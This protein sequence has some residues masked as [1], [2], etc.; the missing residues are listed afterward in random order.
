MT[1]LSGGCRCGKIRYTCDTAPI[2]VSFCYCTD[3]QKAS[4]GPFCNYAVV[5]AEAVT[6]NQGATVHYTVEASTGNVVK[7]EFCAHCG[8][9]LFASTNNVF[10]I[11]VGS[12]DD[13]STVPPAIAIWLDSAQ[14]WAPIPENVERFA[15]N[16]PIT[17]GA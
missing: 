6:V 1:T 17:L 8:A 9:P 2:T 16:P 12:L 3:C 5:P 10:V 11:T 14:P 4:G 15:R 7:R 13:P